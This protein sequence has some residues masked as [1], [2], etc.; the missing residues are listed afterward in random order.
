[1]NISDKLPG[2]VNAA[3]SR[4]H[5]LRTTDLNNRKFIVT[6]NKKSRTMVLKL[7]YTI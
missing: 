1:M 4:E 2:D 3:G 5:T 6:V 7:G